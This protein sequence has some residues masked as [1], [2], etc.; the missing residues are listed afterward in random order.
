MPSHQP[1]RASGGEVTGLPMQENHSDYSRM[2]QLALAL[3]PSGH[4][5]PDSS[6]S[7]QSAY[8][9][10]QSDSSQESVKSKSLCL[11]PRASA[12]Q[13]RGFSGVDFMNGL[14]K[15]PQWFSVSCDPFL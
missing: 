9:A 14:I 10:F 11:V 5:K 3:G 1:A 13:D 2:A 8:P 4:V 15:Y 6:V 12:I 7:A